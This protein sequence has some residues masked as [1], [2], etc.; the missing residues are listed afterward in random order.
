MPPNTKSPA[1]RQ[2]STQGNQF[3]SLPRPQP[4]IAEKP[5]TVND[6]RNHILSIF[7][8]Y[9]FGHEE[10]LAVLKTLSIQVEENFIFETG[11]LRK[12]AMLA[13]VEQ[14]RQQVV[15]KDKKVQVQQDEEYDESSLSI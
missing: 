6:I 4:A 7:E 9:Q 10:I 12:Q 8:Q 13:Q 1:Q 5:L 3:P 15:D 2:P 14:Q 11:R